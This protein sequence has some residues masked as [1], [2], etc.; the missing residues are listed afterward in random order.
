MNKPTLVYHADWGTKP[1]KRWCAKATLGTDG[2]YTASG[3][4][5]VGEPTRLTEYLRTE[6]GA[7]RTVFAGFDFPIGVPAHYAKRAGISKFRNFLR[8]LGQ[9][10]WKDFYSVCDTPEQVSTHRPFYPNQSLEGHLQ[11]HLLDAHDAETM[12]DLLRICERGGNGQRQACSLF[13]TLGAKAVGKAAI[14]GWRDVLAPALKD[15]SIRLWPFDG[16]LQ[17]LFMPGKTVVAET[18]PAECYGWFPGTL[19]ASKTNINSR[20]EFG[21]NLLEWARGSK[22]ALTPQLENAIEAGFPTGEDDA[23]DAVVGL[24]GMLQVCLEQ[25]ATGEPDD[26]TV[27]E[28]EGWILGRQSPT[29][30]YTTSPYSA[31]TDPELADWL[32]WASESGEASNFL[33]A[34]AEAAFIADLEDYALLRQVLLELRRHP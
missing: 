24:F 29:V 26:K 31:T 7:L 28:I 25:R 13:W 5:P 3:P 9:D 30:E 32:H 12:L 1:S 6:A 22:V 33:R 16:K 10:V 8:Q 23:F 14:V 17:P 20:Q 4:T 19:L 15:K 2:R 27:R 11:Q 18:Y 21:S 34:V